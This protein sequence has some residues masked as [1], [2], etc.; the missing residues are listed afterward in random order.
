MKQ[1]INF[2]Y[3]MV[4]YFMLK[5]AKVLVSQGDAAESF[6]HHSTSTQPQKSRDGAR[7]GGADPGSESGA[8]RGPS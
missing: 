7:K 3:N 1:T 2:Y 5:E 4:M 6:L 8:R